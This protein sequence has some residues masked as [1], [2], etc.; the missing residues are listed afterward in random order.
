MIICHY[1]SLASFL[2]GTG[3]TVVNQKLKDQI[4]KEASVLEA[5]IGGRV[6]SVE[7]EEANLTDFSWDEQ[8][9]SL[10]TSLYSDIAHLLDD[11]LR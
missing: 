1:Q 9:F 7:R 11:K 8:G 4:G 6:S 3:Q 2:L 10:M 5:Q